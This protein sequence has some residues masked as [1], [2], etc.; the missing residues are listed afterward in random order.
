VDLIETSVSDRPWQTWVL[1]AAALL[2]LALGGAVL[3]HFSMATHP[4]FLNL[5]AAVDSQVAILDRRIFVFEGVPVEF[6]SWRNRVL[7]PLAMKA[8]TTVTRASDSQ[9]YLVVRW[10]SACAALAAFAWLARV[11]TGAGWW[12]AGGGAL[13]FAFSLFPTF[14]HLYE[15]PSDFFDAAFFSLLIG[16]ALR[17]QRAL[18]IAALLVGLLNRESAIFALAAWWLVHAWPFKREAFSRESLFC[19]AL[20]II[21]SALVTGLRLANGMLTSAANNGLQP[22]APLTMLRAHWT[23]VLDYLHHPTYGNPLF[24]LGAYLLFVALVALAVG[25][26]LPPVLQR[27]GWLAAGLYVLSIAYGNIDEL[28]INIPALVISTLLLVAVA[29]REARPAE[30]P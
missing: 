19:A 30:A 15:V 6:P 11:A 22:F 25:R 10:A 26:S 18:F 23:M 12:L 1:R 5:R 20:A 3:A 28:R 13:V 21:G 24:F 9:A 16:F 7:V 14:L 4:R 8:V 2:A 27:L 17:K 29:V